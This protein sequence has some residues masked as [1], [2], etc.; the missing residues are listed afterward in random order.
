MAINTTGATANGTA[1]LD[2]SSSLKGVLI[3]RMTSAQRTGI[4]TPANGLLVY[5]NDSLAFAYYN[6]IDWVL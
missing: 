3:P 2:V 5:D 1:I 6:G 4:A